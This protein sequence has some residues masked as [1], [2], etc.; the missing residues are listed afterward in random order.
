[1][2][3]LR[4][5]VDWEPNIIVLAKASSNLAVSQ[6]VRCWLL[7][8]RVW[9]QFR[10][11]SCDIR[12]GRSDTGVGFP[13]SF[14][15]FPLLI[16]SPP[17]LHTHLL[18]LPEVCHSPYQAARYNI[19]GVYI[20]ALASGSTFVWFQRK[21]VMNRYTA[22]NRQRTGSKRDYCNLMSKKW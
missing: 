14:F 10:V 9:Y 13:P 7:N 6:V 2:R 21:G 5:L 3:T 22:R 20:V 4:T 8:S 17:L 12:C 18:P 19:L 1:M 11:T 16:T 15:S